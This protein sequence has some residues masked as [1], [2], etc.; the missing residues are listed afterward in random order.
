MIKFM[1]CRSAAAEHLFSAANLTRFPFS[2]ESSYQN[3][4]EAMP[5]YL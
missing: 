2:D 4:I 3:H 5:S 1:G